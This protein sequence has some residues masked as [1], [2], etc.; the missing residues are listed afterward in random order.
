MATT[1]T[2]QGPTAHDLAALY[3]GVGLHLFP[4]LPASKTP[5]CKWG[6]L[7]LL[8]TTEPDYWQEHPDH[9]IGIAT[10]PASGCWVLDLDTSEEKGGGV[11]LRR[12]L[13]LHGPLPRTPMVRT[14]SNG[15]HAYFWYPDNGEVRNSVCR[16]GPGVDVRGVG[17]Y[18]YAPSPSPHPKTGRH[19][20]WIV[21]PWEATFAP[22]PHWLLEA[23][24]PPPPKV[25]SIRIRHRMAGD[26]KTVER[27]RQYINAMPPMIQG[28]G[29]RTRLWVAAIAC[30]RKLALDDTDSLAVLR[31][32]NARADPPWTD[33]ELQQFI[34]DAHSHSTVPVGC[35]L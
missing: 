23:T 9:G 6:G 25:V 28:Q 19:Y 27:A 32:Y 1:Q 34:R 26:P 31:E 35:W 30:T 7:K 24:Q 13:D 4:L 18:V 14:G 11:T 8:P 17:G 20:I 3:R 10:G 2:G 15:L 16:V 21:A 22:A 33:D 12:L 29:G 5:A